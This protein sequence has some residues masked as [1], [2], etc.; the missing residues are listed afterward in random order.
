MIVQ[1]EPG[2]YK[3][4]GPN[5]DGPRVVDQNVNAFQHAWFNLL[6]ANLGYRGLVKWDAY[7]A[8]YD[9]QPE[10]HP[11]EYGMIGKPND[12]GWQLRQSYYLTRLFTQTV[13]PG[14]NV[15]ELAHGPGSQIVAAYSAPSGGGLTLIGLDTAGASLNEAVPEQ[16]SYQFSKLPANKAFALLYWNQHGRGL[17]TSAGKVR[18]D[19]AGNLT[20]EAPLNSVFA[21]TT[22][23]VDV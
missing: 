4:Q 2:T 6:A 10:P 7:F 22:V 9:L 15:R 14:W 5:L 8:K 13:K 3:P 16:R 21:V 23:A 11:Q 20:V 19:R 1:P 18:T 12:S 17:L